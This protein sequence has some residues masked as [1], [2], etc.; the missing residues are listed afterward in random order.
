MVQD[1]NGGSVIGGVEEMG[2]C[3]KGGV[4]C[5]VGVDGLFLF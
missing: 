3:V 2:V 4:L 5:Y 1:G